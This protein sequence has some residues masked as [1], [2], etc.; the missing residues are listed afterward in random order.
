[1]SA[2]FSL[3]AIGAVV[4]AST[5]VDDI[6]VLLGFFSDPRFRVRQVVLGQYLGIGALIAASV[7]L[8]LA[9]F[10]IPRAY[11]GL[12]G[13]APLTIGIWKVVAREAASAEQPPASA[14]ANVLAVT[15]VTLANGAD[16]LAAYTPLFATR[17]LW[18]VGLLS[19]VFLVIAGLW[20]G[21]AH[22][23]TRHPS[24]GQPIRKYGRILLPWVLMALG[25]YILVGSGTFRLIS[26]SA[27]PSH[28][29]P[30]D[31]DRGG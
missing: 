17:R 6:F 11:I 1:M 9:S 3:V 4:F 19:T 14:R 7:V 24:V 23:L 20:C 10:V 2:S 21:V 31:L 25:L 13:F 28:P 5:N 15:A 30:E 26:K 18:E 27:A 12:L 22:R 8:A 29:T 16:N